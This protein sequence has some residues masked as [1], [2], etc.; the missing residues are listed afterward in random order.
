MT[1]VART[2][3]ASKRVAAPHRELALCGGLSAVRIPIRI[4]RERG[5]EAHV[6]RPRGGD[7]RSVL[8][9]SPRR[10]TRFRPRASADVSPALARA[11]TR[12]TNND[13]RRR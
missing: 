6:P 5:A 2:Q 8:E 1:G 13:S 11:R 3:T 10:E 7:P 12:E 4:G 9:G